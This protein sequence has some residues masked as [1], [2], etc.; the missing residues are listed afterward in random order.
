[1]PTLVLAPRYTPDSIAM[2]TAAA[3]AGW[4]VE[5]LPS[6]RVPD[7]LKG[8]RHVALYAEPLFASAVA[9]ELDLALLEPPL[10]WLIHLPQRYTCRSVR[11]TTLIEAR[12]GAQPFFIKPAD[13]KC[14]P[15]RVYQSGDGLPDTGLLP[16]STPVLVAE[17]VEWDIE[18]RLFVLNRLVVTYSPYLRQGQ[19]ARTADGAWTTATEDEIAAALEFSSRVLADGTISLPPAVALDVGFIKGRGWAVVEANAAWGAGIYGCEPSAV[20][21]V[22]QRACVSKSAFGSEDKAWLVDRQGT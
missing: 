10:D 21:P 3:T 16:D 20:L 19:L 1:M 8:R 9:E 4:D 17:P 2:G 11:L 5:R 14:F 7:W 22:V 15:A 18:F 6:W 12:G 13:D